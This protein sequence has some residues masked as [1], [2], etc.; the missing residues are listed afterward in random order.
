MGET[1]PGA[2]PTGPALYTKKQV[3]KRV[4][5]RERGDVPCKK[6]NLTRYREVLP[7]T[8]APEK[9]KRATQ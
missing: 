4:Q 9:R 8:P 3:G 7:G 5:V 6:V 1:F 2:Y